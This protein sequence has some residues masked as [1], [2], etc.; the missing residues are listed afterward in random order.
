MQGSQYVGVGPVLNRN[1]GGAGNL[2][3]KAWGKQFNGAT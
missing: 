2:G 3:E 1:V